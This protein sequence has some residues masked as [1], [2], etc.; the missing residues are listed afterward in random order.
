MNNRLLVPEKTATGIW[1]I[2]N[3][4][5]EKEIVL[6]SAERTFYD[7]FISPDGSLFFRLEGS[8][9]KKYALA[10]PWDIESIGPV[11]ASYS[12]SYSNVSSFLFNPNGTRLYIESRYDDYVREFT[13]STAWDITNVSYRYAFKIYYLGDVHS[14][15]FTSDG[16]R[17]FMTG[18]A[19][20][21]SSRVI[22]Y[23]KYA[24]SNPFVLPMSYKSSLTTSSQNPDMRGVFFN[25]DGT[26]MFLASDNGYVY[27]YAL[28]IPWEISTAV[29][30]CSFHYAAPYSTNGLFFDPT[31]SKMYFLSYNRILQ[32]TLE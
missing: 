9:I 10:I 26:K 32:F 6:T 29:Y 3:A 11:I 22:Q 15:F 16:E 20:S 8:Y 31:G 27:Q 7:L 14:M 4:A 28:N 5:F 24:G 13:L 2:A 17:L 19:S 18:D 23:D 12:F 30:C 21:S 1:D 25:P